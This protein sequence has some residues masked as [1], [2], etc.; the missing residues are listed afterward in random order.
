MTNPTG[1]NQQAG[2]WIWT[3]ACG[4][5]GEP[6]TDR[7]QAR[8]AYKQHR[9]SC[10]APSP[11]EGGKIMSTT[12]SENTT[13]APAAKKKAVAGGKKEGGRKKREQSVSEADAKKALANLKKGDTTLIAESKKLGFSHNG[14]LRAALRT[15]IGRD[16]YDKLMEAGKSDVKAAKKKPAAKKSGAK[17]PANK[18]AEVPAVE[19]K[20]TDSSAPALEIVK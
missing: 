18:A 3:C 14:P 17:K 1:I 5:S 6:T 9:A 13:K 15:L 16:A 11:Q 7:E 2:S 19:A 12:A 20:G 10:G 8:S 4:K